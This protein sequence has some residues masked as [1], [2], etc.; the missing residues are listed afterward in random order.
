MHVLIADRID[1]LVA[2]RLRDAGL[3]VS[4]APTLSG[5]S[6]SA[7]LADEKAAILI[8][9]STKV[10]AEQLRMSPTLQLIIRAGAGVNTIDVE[11]AARRAIYVVNCPGM[12]AAAVA[13][14]AW[15]HIINIDR[16]IVEGVVA[17][18][19]GR[20]AKKAL[21][22]AQGLRGATLGLVGAGSIAREMISIARGFGL[23]VLAYSPRLDEVR[24]RALG[25]TRAPD[26]L[27]LAAGADIVSLHLPLNEES[28][29]S[30]GERFFSAMR[31]GAIFINTSRGELVDEA[32]LA[33]AVQG[34]GLRVGLDVFQ[35]EPKGDGPWTQPLTALPTFYGTPH[36]G[37]STAQ[38]QR[39]V[40]E[41]ACRLALVWAREGRA[42]NCVNLRRERGTVWCLMVRHRDEVGALAVILEM[43]REAGLNI[44]QMQNQIFAGE[45]AAACARLDLIGCPSETLLSTLSELSVVYGVELSA[46]Q[47]ATKI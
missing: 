8:V 4:E 25:V 34:R 2:S 46:P 1:P 21:S 7:A 45:G 10:G 28:R 13:E 12:N 15:G 35:G 16:R 17:L 29:G 14:L 37:A 36:I 9:R 3:T 19:E 41:E 22:A 33:A 20:W 40:A 18:R 24:A 38:A 47:R 44:Q 5:A 27:S 42:E 43:I 26:L 6:L 32:A 39:A 23:S 11:E 31:R 30:F